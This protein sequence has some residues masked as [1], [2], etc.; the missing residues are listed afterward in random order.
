MALVTITFKLSDLGGTP[1]SA[2]NNPRLWVQLVGGSDVGTNMI[3]DVEKRATL[4]V[5]TGVGSAQVDSFPDAL[6]RFVLDWTVPDPRV[7][8]SHW[9]RRRTEWPPFHPGGGGDIS[10]LMPFAGVRGV[11]A[12]FGPVTSWPHPIV[13]LDLADPDGIGVYGPANMLASEES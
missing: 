5:A 4:D 9:A 2:L 11:M 12:G 6:Y 8:P 10:A 13:Y 1:L 3:A 7:E